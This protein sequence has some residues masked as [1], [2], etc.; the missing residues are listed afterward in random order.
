MGVSGSID[1]ET[2]EI[3]NQGRLDVEAKRHRVQAQ[4]KTRLQYLG[5]DL[6]AEG[7]VVITMAASLTL[8]SPGDVSSV[9]A[10][11]Q[12]ASIVGIGRVRLVTGEGE[13]FEGQRIVFR[14]KDEQWFLDG[15]P[16]DVDSKV[17]NPGCK[18]C[19]GG[20]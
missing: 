14:A 10:S 20:G 3:E 4:G 13:I 7:Q 8:D 1:G 11:K 16:I 18:D 15:N 5:F 9:R 19:E 2:V 17:S 12:L 6:Q